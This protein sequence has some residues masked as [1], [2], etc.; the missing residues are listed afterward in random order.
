MNLKPRQLLTAALLS[1]ALTSSACFIAP[2]TA[3]NLATAA[4]WTAAVAGNVL[5]L[6]HHDSHYHYEQCGH[7]RRYHEERWVYYYGDHWEYYDEYDGRWYY[8][9][10]SY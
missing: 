1:L 9:G 8:Y 7:Y 2:R 5:L 4:I 3:A 10:E 6:A